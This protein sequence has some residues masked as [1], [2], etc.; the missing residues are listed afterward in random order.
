MKHLLRFGRRALGVVI[1]IMFV[2][3]GAGCGDDDEPLVVRTMTQ[4]VYYGFDVGPLLSASN[5]EEIPV[6]AAQAFAQ[7]V[8]TNFPERADAIADEIARKRPHLIGLQEVALIRVQSPGDSVAGGTVPAEAVYQDYLEIL[9]AALAVRGLDYRVAG[10]VQNVDVELPMIVGTEPLAFDDVRLTDFDV[11]LARG[12]V[13]VSNVVAQNYQAKLPLANLGVEVPRGYVALDARVGAGRIR[14]AS[15][16]LEDT[17]FAEIQRAQAQE[18]AAALSGEAKPVVLVGDFNSPA[19]DG[20]T[21]AF[22]ASQGYAD[23][24][25]GSPSKDPGDGLTWGHAPDL[26]NETVQLTQ[27]LDLVLTRDPLPTASRVRL[28]CLR[29][30]IWGDEL[31]ERA[32]SGL[33]PSDHAGVSAELAFTL[34]PHR[35]FGGA[36][37]TQ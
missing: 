16:H 21:C 25:V 6:L 1:L 19:P 15:T 4:N 12:D 23:A 5:P 36:P 24:W 3:P 20:D 9:L 34:S 14:F 11:V 28:T 35:G 18:L 8:S 7:L 26:R 13:E 17:P 22:F 37:R 2:A 31:S 29:T 10:K 30:S 33:W 27:R 32:G